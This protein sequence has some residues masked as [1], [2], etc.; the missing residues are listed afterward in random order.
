MNILEMIKEAQRQLRSTQ[1]NWQEP[2]LY[3]CD[4]LLTGAI[5]LL[6]ELPARPPMPIRITLTEELE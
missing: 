5:A 2:C 6:E 3:K 1:I 4:D